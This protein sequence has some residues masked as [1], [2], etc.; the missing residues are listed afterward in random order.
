VKEAN[1]QDTESATDKCPNRVLL[2]IMNNKD[3]SRAMV[4]PKRCVD[5]RIQRTRQVLQQAFME[6]V[7]EKGFAATRIQDITERAN[8]NRGTFYI[9]FEDKYRLLDIVIRE[10]FRQQLA[11]RL[12]PG[13]RWDRRTLH[14]LIQ[15]VLDCF[16]SKYRHQPAVLSLK[17]VIPNEKPLHLAPSNYG[18]KEA[19]DRPIAT[20]LVR[21]ARYA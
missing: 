17:Q 15:A 5:R 9:H 13:P 18:V 2:Y 16:E 8:V 11:S 7:Q 6:V 12:P 3:R 10:Q 14:L 4:T 21:P 19:L 1:K 20:S